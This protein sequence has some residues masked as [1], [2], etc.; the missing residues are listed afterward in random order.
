MKRNLKPFSVEIK[1]SRIHGQ[2]TQLQP[3]RL[4]ETAQVEAR[5]TFRKEEPQAMSEQTAP[6]RILPS[7][8]EPEWSSPEPV[9]PVRRKRSS[10]SKAQQEQVEL[11]LN[12]LASED[13]REAPAEPAM[14]PATVSQADI[15]PVEEGTESIHQVQPQGS[16]SRRARP[17][18]PR[19][20]APQFVGPVEASKPVSKSAPAEAEPTEPPPE[21]PW[22][23]VGHHRLSKRQ[24]AVAQLPRHERWKRRLHPASW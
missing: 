10:K 1:K 21:V 12:A 3:R 17:G 14:V 24:A 6:R 19:N 20:E 22:H 8:V 15:E 9:E 4:F 7:L 23:R 2:R 13:V 18:K 11:D 16:E 5:K